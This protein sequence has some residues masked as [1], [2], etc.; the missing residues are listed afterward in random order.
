MTFS[1][2]IDVIERYEGWDIIIYPFPHESPEITKTVHFDTL[3]KV[4]QWLHRKIKMG[5]NIQYKICPSS[6]IGLF[7][8][9]TKYKT[10]TVIGGMF[11]N[12]ICFDD[13]INK[14]N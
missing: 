6:I 14:I 3:D 1:Y 9:L 10:D 8:E 13:M 7:P 5:D 2:A 12:R 4:I 11:Y